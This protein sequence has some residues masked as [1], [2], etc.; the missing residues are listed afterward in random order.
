MR[1]LFF[2][3]VGGGEEIFLGIDHVV[4]GP[5]DAAEGDA[6][7]EGLVVE[8]EALEGLLDDG[9]LI[10]LVVDGE[11]AGEA[12]VAD[13]EGFDV[14]A[15]DAHAEAVEGGDGGLREGG[16]A[17]DFFDALAHLLGGLVGEGDGQ[18][19]VGGDAALL[20]EVGD[21]MSDDA[22]FAAAGAGEE[23]H[24][25][26]DGED[27]LALLG[28]HVGEEVGHRVYFI[29]L[30][31]GWFAGRFRGLCEGM[32][33]FAVG[34]NRGAGIGVGMSIA[35][36]LNHGRRL[37]RSRICEKEE[38]NMKRLSVVTAMVLSASL[39]TSEAMFAMPLAVHAP[40]HAMLSGQKL[41]KFNVHNATTA[42]IKVKA[43]D[44]E[45]TLPPGKD[46]PLK[47]PVGSKV[48]VE[49][50]S[51]HYPVGNVLTVVS[52]DLSEATLI[53]N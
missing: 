28:V 6:G 38:T 1:D 21:A 24:G 17:E 18:D 45:L 53:L 19:V 41:V 29:E 7:L 47:L 48:V 10:G 2:D 37:V 43:G 46:V 25:A 13:A 4:L 51:T 40:V 39:L 9:L 32:K 22:G 44:A 20:D 49:E 15:E 52:N 35:N 14:A 30:S 31:R 33:N 34:G 42:P 12:G 23:K 27:A 50:A 36:L 3:G 8:M 5:G 16:V 26:V 11:A